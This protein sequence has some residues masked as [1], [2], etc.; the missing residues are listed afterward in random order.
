MPRFGSIEIKVGSFYVCNTQYLKLTCEGEKLSK[1]KAIPLRALRGCW[2]SRRFEVPRI[3]RKSAHEGGRAVSPTQKISLVLISIRGRVDPRA[4]ER[5]PTA[6]P[7]TA[8]L[9]SYPN[10]L[11]FFG[12]FPELRKATL[13]FVM[14]VCPSIFQHGTTRLPLEGVL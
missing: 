14:S 4:M 3:P 8:K 7:R 9:S 6:P 5:Q 2:G 1:S 12:A 10:N 13:S 11:S